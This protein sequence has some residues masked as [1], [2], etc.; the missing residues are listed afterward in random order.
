EVLGAIVDP[1]YR[2]ERF[3][4]P[5]F[6][7]RSGCCKHTRPERLRELNCRRP[8]A[9]RAAMD[10]HVFTR[11]AASTLEQVRPDGEVIFRQ[12]GRF[13]HAQPCG[14]R[15]AKRGGCHGVLRVTTA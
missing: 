15:E 5:G 14:N 8:Y 1:P 11:L 13:N 4:K 10:E 9:T 12:R 6:G 2:A 3:A 7:V